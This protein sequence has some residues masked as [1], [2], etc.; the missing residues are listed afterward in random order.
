MD[1]ITIKPDGKERLRVTSPF[2]KAR[3]ERIRRIP[4]RR[5]LPDDKAWSVP[6]TPDTLTTPLPFPA[7]TI[8]VAPHK[9][10]QLAPHKNP[11]TS[12]PGKPLTANPPHPFI[13]A[14]GDELVLRGEDST[15]YLSGR[16]GERVFAAAK[17]REGNQFPQ[18][19][20]GDEPVS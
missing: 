4:G 8:T 11:T 5:W 9:P 2:S 12:I 18:K 1:G 6:D 15:D 16:S 13:K 19:V 3:I 20:N 7:T 14:V 10:G 17:E